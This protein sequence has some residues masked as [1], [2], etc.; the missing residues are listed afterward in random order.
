MI[1][2]SRSRLYVTRPES[3]VAGLQLK[4]TL[5]GET[6]TTF[7]LVGAVGAFVSAGELVAL[8]AVQAPRMV[9][10]TLP[11]SGNPGVACPACAPTLIRQTAPKMTIVNGWNSFIW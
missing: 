4:T 9:K 10:G 6:V 3:S 2:P 5:R 1:V 11:S 8:S 7:R